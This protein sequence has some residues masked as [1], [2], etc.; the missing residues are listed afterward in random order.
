MKNEFF[1]P[2]FPQSRVTPSSGVKRTSSV[3]EQ[4]GN[5][6]ANVLHEIQEK[7]VAFQPLR[8][9]AHAQTRMRE[10]GVQMTDK[11]WN[12]LGQAVV[13]AAEKGAKDA[14]VMY[15]HA[16]FVVNVPNRTVITTMVDDEPSVITNIDS[17]VIVPRLDH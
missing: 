14:Y 8:I 12:K 2:F 16:G 11:D 5:S 4:N 17:V 15:G 1:P 6:F 3:Q 7:Q 13:K 9:S 10:R